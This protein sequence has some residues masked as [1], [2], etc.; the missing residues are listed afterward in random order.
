MRKEYFGCINFR[1][2][3]C[4]R[5]DPSHLQ[6]S[7]HGSVTIDE[8]EVPWVWFA[9]TNE[10]VVKTYAVMPDGK[11][12]S[13]RD[14]VFDPSAVPKRVYLSED[15]PGREVECPLDGVLSETLRGKVRI[16]GPEMK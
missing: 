12:H 15:F 16:F 11:P 10:G 14:R 9:D 1:A 13:T 2:P 3:E 6:E 8:H 7:M 4:L 5:F